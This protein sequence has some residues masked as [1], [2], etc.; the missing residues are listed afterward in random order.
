M[1]TQQIGLR[2][3]DTRSGRIIQNIMPTL[4]L[5][6]KD[7]QEGNWVTFVSGA[8]TENTRQ[9]QFKWGVDA[10]TT[11]SD[12]TSASATA[13]ATSIAVTN[14]ARWVPGITAINT[15]TGE[16]VYVEAV[17]KATG[18][19]TVIRAITALASAG[20]TAAAAMNSGDTLV[21]VAP[22]VGEDSRRQT[23]EHTVEAEISN[24]CQQMRREVHLSRRQIKRSFDSQESELPYQ[25]MKEMLEFRRF[26][27]AAFLVGEKGRYTDSVMGDVTLTQ[28]IRSAITTYTYAVGGTL[29]QANF[30][31]WLVKEALRKANRNKLMV[32]S[33]TVILA[34][35]EMYNDLAHFTAPMAAGKSSMGVQVMSV[36]APNGGRLTIVE[37]R[38]LSENFDGE[39]YVVDMSHIKRKVFSNHGLNDD[40]HV[41]S[42][43]G[44]NDDLGT[45]NTLYA[46]TGLQYGAEEAHGKITGV[47]GG[48]KGKA[49]S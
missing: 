10:L 39:A 7:L 44:D 17:N 19:I 18:N 38:Y 15:R 3:Y 16:H 26:L 8:P 14:I 43:T 12:T 21:R 24:Y 32:C 45:N 13:T 40:L 25:M 49:V 37:D 9:E 5:L 47:T 48:A 33:A 2:Q 30:N 29:Y 36:V 11:Q 4:I 28:G 41:I 27:D 20:G 35:T 31:D 22:V 46:D 42:D 34:I 6:D 23:A 1:A